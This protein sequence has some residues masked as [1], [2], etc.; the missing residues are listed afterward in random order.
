M[1]AAPPPFP[2]LAAPDGEAPPTRTRLLMAALRLFAEQ[3]YAK[4]SI[5]AIAQA[6]QA[7][8]AAV[9]YHFGDKAALYAALFSEP[10]GDT[11][12][13]IAEFTRPELTLRQALHSYFAMALA[14]L[15]DG[16]I[17]RL[18][19][20]L[21]IRE[22]LDPTEQW[23]QQLEKDVRAPHNAMAALL[24]RHM[25]LAAP[26]DDLH[27]LVLSIAGLAF[28]LWGQQEVIAAIQP[29][30]LATPQ[31]LDHWGSR[32]TDYAV[33]MVEVEQRLRS[34]A[35][36]AV[37]A[38]SPPSSK[39]QAP[40]APRRRASPAAATDAPPSPHDAP[41]PSAAPARRR[42]HLPSP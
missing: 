30:L 13:L 38:P 17:A 5:R 32:M 7:N 29:Q 11:A 39:T 1:T 12:A 34:A 36:P 40:A 10:C 3:G 18:Y 8:V 24:C 19:V 33:A 23:A 20:H 41:A 14:P 16:E 21:H 35:P 9:S 25:G 15:H 6:A 28:Q 26:D 2:G 4:T 22:M 27:R 37:P 42:K 31:A